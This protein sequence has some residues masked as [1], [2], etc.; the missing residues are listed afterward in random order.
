MTRARLL[1]S[2]L[3]GASAIPATTVDAL[4]TPAA[5]LLRIDP[6]ASIHDG[7]PT[8]TT[9]IDVV[10]FKGLSDAL[11]PCARAVGTDV[12]DCWSAQLEKPH[13]LWVPFPFPGG[14]AQLLVQVSGASTPTRF[15]DEAQW[16]AAQTQP[17]VG[18]AWLV[19]VD[20][21]SGMGPRFLDAREIA[22][23]LVAEMR[24]G[25]LMDLMF[26]DD[27]QTVRDTKWITYAK[28]AALADALNS[29]SATMPSHGSNRALF[30]QI[31]NMT[32]DAFGSL[33]NFD[34]PDEVPLHQAMV[35]LSNG[36]GRGDPESASP[37]A[38]AFHQYLDGGRFPP[39]NTSLPKT[40]LPVVSIWLPNPAG[41]L[42]NVY[43]NNEAQFM[44][45]LAN[46]EIGGFFDV[47]RQGQGAAKAKTIASRV[48]ERFDAMWVVHWELSCIN[49]SLE[50][51]FDLEFM[52][53]SPVISGDGTFKDVPLGIDPTT[54]PLDVDVQKTVAAAT[55]DPVFAGGQ[56]T[57]YGTFCWSGDATQAEAYFVPAGSHPAST[58][59]SFGPA[60][61]QA[62]QQLKA[63]N[64]V[65]KAVKAADGYVVFDV[66]DNAAVLDATGGTPVT[67]LVVYDNK[68]HRSS[69]IDAKTIL[70]LAAKKKPLSWPLVGG[71]GGLSAVV[72]LLAA[73]A[74][75]GG[76]G[77]RKPGVGR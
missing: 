59:G 68:A 50:Q 46:P 63:E 67:R 58:S 52:N 54:W 6:R 60:A 29:L 16:G 13:A 55:A 20:A 73:V 77:R 7:K 19:S 9:V 57:V 72:A 61:L 30:R 71:I 2:L 15:L 43:A 18:T 45:A 26:F 36:A 23:E 44:Q 56:V 17:N 33:G 32:Q 28:R 8:L 10:Q 5:H 40:P 39:D 74:A 22:H 12:L 76:N 42:E 49:P 27:V 51:T 4:A 37:S 24:P 48:R 3:L 53:T 25:D 14:N 62:M 66:P 21:S 70:T 69:S 1:L 11:L 41:G 31:E 64:M 35:I 47:V 65:G 34:A 75:R 38:D